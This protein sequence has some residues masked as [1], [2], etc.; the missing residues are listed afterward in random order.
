MKQDMTDI[1]FG[2]LRLSLGIGDAGL[3][4]ALSDEE[5]GWVYRLSVKQ[6]LLGL[7][8]AAV[9]KLPA[10]R[11]PP[12]ALLLR[13][14]H[15]SMR[16]SQVNG[17]M[18]SMAARVTELFADR[19]LH[20]V[21]LKGQAN[22]RLYPDPMARQAGDIDV[23]IEGGRGGVLKLLK[24]MGLLQ[25]D[26]STHHVHLNQKDFDGITVEV[27][28]KPCSSFS[29]RYNRNMQEFLDGEL[30]EIRSSGFGGSALRPAASG[31]TPDAVHGQTHAVMSGLTPEGFCVPPVSF[32][33]VM[34]MSHIKQ[35]FFG[36]GVGLRQLVD[37]CLL[38]RNSSAEDRARVAE[39]LKDFGLFRMA[40][41]VMWVMRSVFGLDSSLLLCKPDA[42]RGKWLLNVV[43]KGGNLGKF[44][45]DYGSFVL[46]RWL[47]DRKRSLRMLRFDA[48]EA[49]W[50]EIRYWK[51]TLGLMPRR[52]K[53]RR[54]ALGKR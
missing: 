17:R 45:D 53:R 38:L 49:I 7:L 36:T 5:W 37:Y 23:L 21:I 47:N 40:G 41:A 8:Y 39:R 35:H 12:R 14:A 25:G 33:L 31:L 19:G 18:N 48:S 16:I 22:A 2:L 28:F 46:K 52:I 51:Q 15:D 24:E 42:R 1:Y 44:A 54:L 20:P 50:H 43:L 13:L 27:H 34:Q 11:R 6:S 9:Q 26:V 30:M 3:P 29:P 10:D 32:A 4:R